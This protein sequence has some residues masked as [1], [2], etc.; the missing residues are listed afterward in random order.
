MLKGKKILL[1]ISGG[2][3]AYKCPELIR[4][5]MAEG[6]EVRVVTTQNALWF[7]TPVTLQTLSRNK[8][9]SEVF[10]PVSQF[11]PE[12]ISHADWADALLVAPATANIIGKFANGIADDALSTTFLAFDKPVFVAPAM[13]DKMYE[14]PVVQRNIRE[15]RAIDGQ[16]IEPAYGE[17]A[18]GSV[19]KGRM[20]EPE[21][22]VAFLE[23]ALV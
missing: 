23:D 17:L 1:G 3:A 14:H 22:I 6:A 19:G 20:E 2:I 15:L 5:L 7:V 21:N 12:H 8:V 16:F 4:Q 9:Y 10:E 11:N 18:C 13:N